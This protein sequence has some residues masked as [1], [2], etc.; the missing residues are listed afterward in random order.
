MTDNYLEMIHIGVNDIAQ[1][2]MN[3][4]EKWVNRGI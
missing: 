1:I 2:M 3:L 4:H